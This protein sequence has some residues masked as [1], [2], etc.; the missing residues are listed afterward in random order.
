VKNNML[1]EFSTIYRAK[2]LQEAYL[3]R[4]ILQE[5]GI[6]ATIANEVLQGGSGVDIVGWPTLPRVV[7]AEEDSARARE[8]AEEFDRDASGGRLGMRLNP[9]RTALEAEVVEAWPCCPECGARRLT[10]CT[11]CGTSGSDFPPADAN[12]GDLLG[13]PTPPA[14]AFSSCSCG[15]GGCGT[16]GVEV[17]GETS[18][19]GENDETVPSTDQQ[20]ETPSSPLLI[21]PTCDEPFHPQYLRRCEWCGHEF[22]DGLDNPLPDEKV[23]EPF[24]WR[25]AYVIYAL[26]LLTLGVMVYLLLLF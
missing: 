6:R 10:R 8:I 20:S 18:A 22:S 9:E 14:E 7:V 13:L 23:Q 17:E 4:N 19:A 2:N 16:H 1:Q 5:E 21:C 24:N 3:L 26:A 12:T 15:P 11:I 25:I